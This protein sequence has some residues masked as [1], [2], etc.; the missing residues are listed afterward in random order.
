CHKPEFEA[1]DGGAHGEETRDDAGKVK[2]CSSCHGF[3][4]TEVADRRSILKEACASCHKEG[5]RQLRWG[6]RFAAAADPLRG[7]ALRA[8]RVGQHAASEAFLDRLEKPALPA[9]PAYNTRGSGPPWGLAAAAAASLGAFLA[10]ILRG[11][12]RPAS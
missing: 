11:Q 12:G 4:A 5:S 8:A 9:R 3:H 2:G 7:D 1:F 6:G 10:W